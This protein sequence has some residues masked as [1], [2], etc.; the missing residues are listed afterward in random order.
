VPSGAQVFTLTGT[1]RGAR[2]LPDHVAGQ[3]RHDEPGRA[4]ATPDLFTGGSVN[5]GAGGGT[6]FIA[7]SASGVL[8]TDASVI[9]K[10]GWGTSN[11]P[12][13]SAPTGNSITL[14]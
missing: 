14:S 10:I 6:L 12:E 7:A 1:V 8:P 3:R 9:D 11:S 5:P 4:A 2:S 13:T